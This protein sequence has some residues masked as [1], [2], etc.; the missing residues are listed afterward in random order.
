MLTLGEEAFP[1]VWLQRR[2]SKGD[3]G[4]AAQLCKHHC[5]A[6]VHLPRH[7]CMLTKSNIQFQL[8]LQ[9]R[10]SKGLQKTRPSFTETTGERRGVA[11][12]SFVDL[13]VNA[14]DKATGESLSDLERTNQAFV[15][16]MSGESPSGTVE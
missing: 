16:V 11:P 7:F 1:H 9:R 10:E 12:G 6:Q 13:L 5:T 4:N 14:T 8:L 3:A 2:E 15:M